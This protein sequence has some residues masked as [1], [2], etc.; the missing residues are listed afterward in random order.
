MEVIFPLIGIAFILFV[1]YFI[2]KILE[3]VIM[4][5]NLYKKIID[6][7]DITIKLLLDIRDTTKKY[8]SKANAVQNINVDASS[9]ENT[10]ICGSCKTE[11]SSNAKKCPKCGAQFD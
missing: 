7:Q 5:I 8:N 3:F 4:A 11:V 1:I 2:F 6:R 10:F 9:E